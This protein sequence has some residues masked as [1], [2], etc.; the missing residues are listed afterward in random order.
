MGHPSCRERSTQRREEVSTQGASERSLHTFDRPPRVRASPK[1]TE[2]NRE[3]PSFFS[4]MR[5]DSHLHFEVAY[6]ELLSQWCVD[7]STHRCENALC[8]SES[9]LDSLCMNAR[10]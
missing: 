1:I 6:I 9:Q 10:V 2:S 4:I 8:V 7:P 3:S 5:L